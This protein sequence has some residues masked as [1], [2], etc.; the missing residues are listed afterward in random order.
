MM[1]L[2]LC[3]LLL[4]INYYYYYYYYYSLFIHVTASALA[5]FCAVQ[6]SVFATTFPS[7]ASAYDNICQVLGIVTSGREQVSRLLLNLPLSLVV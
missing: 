5:Q 7:G 4:E 2:L 6:V 3:M 1:Y